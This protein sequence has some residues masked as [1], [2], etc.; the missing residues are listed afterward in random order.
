M[1]VSRRAVFFGPVDGIEEPFDFF[2]AEG[3]D[4]A[5]GDFA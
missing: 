5:F 4:A 3:F 1:A 2:S